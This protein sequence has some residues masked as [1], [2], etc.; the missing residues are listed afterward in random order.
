MDKD[1]VTELVKKIIPEIFLN[2]I[3]FGFQWLVLKI[4]FV[5]VFEE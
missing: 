5:E 1:E 4:F 2:A 3:P